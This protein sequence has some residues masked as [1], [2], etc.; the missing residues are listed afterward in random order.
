[1]D[2]NAFEHDSGHVRK[3]KEAISSSN[4]Y[5][6][7]TAGE[8]QAEKRAIYKNVLLISFSFLLLFTAFESMSKLQSS[9]NTVQNLGT[10]SS[11][12]VYVSL[13]LSCMFMPSI[14]IK[15]LK[16][17][18]TLVVCIFCYSTYMAA[19][20]YPEFYTLIPTA[21]IL[22][23][24]AAPM[25][26][27]KCTYLNQVAHRLAQLEGL[28]AELVVVK[29]FAIFFF[30][31]QCNSIIG[32]IISTTVLSSGG[33]DDNSTSAIAE[34]DPEDDIIQGCG[35]GYCPAS[36]V[37][38]NQTESSGD[39]N[40]NF[41]T[42]IT[43]IYII[44]GIFLGCSLSA[45]AIIAIFVDPL[46]RFGEDERNSEREE[47]TGVQLLVAT[48]RHMRH[49]NQILVIPITI[50]SG[51][52][53]GFFNAAFTAGFVTCAYG[54][55]VIGRVVIVFGICNA[56]FSF[57]SGYIIKVVGRPALFV[58][59]AVMNIIVI[60]VMLSWTPRVSQEWVVYILGA[61]WGLG[62]AVWQT[63]INALYGALFASQEEAAFSNYRM[64]ESLGFVIA[65]I[66]SSLS[67]CVFPMIIG[68][69]VFLGCGLLGYF[70]VEYL[71]HCDKRKQVINNNGHT[72]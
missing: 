72:Y 31:F 4:V 18:W 51:I 36:L 2:N 15:W 26:S 49:R 45:A 50:W 3:E 27:A 63:Q 21:L 60:I 12:A 56:S 58:F 22:G 41:A 65:F 10:W 28:A 52:E 55:H 13:I 8:R 34:L 46:T 17:K 39:T 11:T 40:E 42:D 59:G 32:S 16:V 66:T 64:W 9:I 48:F 37:T 61:M 47:L 67:V 14:L 24:G 25:W 7:L 35:S 70:S 43:K 23:L 53:Q 19:Q 30:F 62:D 71:E 69:I 33:S 20:F 54:A 6:N 68:T 57:A 38:V 29:F 1:M 44:A 5:Q